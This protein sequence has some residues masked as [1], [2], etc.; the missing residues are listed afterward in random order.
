MRDERGD[1][2]ELVHDLRRREAGRAGASWAG[3]RPTEGGRAGGVDGSA[4]PWAR[5][6]N[7]GTIDTGTVA[8]VPMVQVWAAPDQSLGG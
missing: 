2:L 4:T 8:P 6:L 7:D 5:G 3:R 1:D